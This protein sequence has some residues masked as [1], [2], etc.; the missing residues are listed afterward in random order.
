VPLSLYYWREG[1]TWHLKDL[2]NPANPFEDTLAVGK[3][4]ETE[5]SDALFVKL[6]AKIHFPKGIIHF[7]VPRGR[8]GQVKTTAPT[9]WH[10]YLAYIGMGVALVGTTLV[11]FGTGTVVVAGT[12]ILAGSGVIGAVAAGGDLA[13][14]LEHGNLD[15]TTAVIDI[16][17]IV[18]GLAGAAALAQGAIALDAANAGTPWAGKWAQLAV[19]GEKTRYIPLGTKVAADVVTVVAMAGKTAEQLDQIESS[20]GSRADRDR[21]KAQLLA[22]FALSGGLVALSIKGDLGTLGKGRTLRL[23]MPKEGP[24][25]ALLSGM[26][27]PTG[28]KFSQKDVGARTGDG[29]LTIEELTENMKKGGWDGEPIHVVELADGSTVS[30]DNRRLLAAQNAGLKEI[31][32][33]VP[34]PSGEARPNA[35]PR[36]QARGQHPQAR[37]W[38]P[39]SRRY[40]GHHRLREGSH[41]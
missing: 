8:G 27:A 30:L 36:V 3:P 16:A 37:R 4:D 21:A 22:Q 33:P 18:A 10:E 34:Q 14:H 40:Q 1:D 6:D 32:G 7:Q 11:T 31:P 23:Y 38:Q 20:G 2:T 28:L 25:V 41:R 5:P 12:W 29:E 19:F 9:S 24:P 13:E 39:G 15:A 35:G 26:E 17:Q